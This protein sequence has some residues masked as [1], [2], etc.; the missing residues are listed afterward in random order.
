VAGMADRVAVMYGG[1]IVEQAPV[2]ALFAKPVHPYTAGLLAAIPRLP[3]GPPFPGGEG[4]Q[5][6]RST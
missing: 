4:G 6:V 3:G 5:G 2:K 1:Q